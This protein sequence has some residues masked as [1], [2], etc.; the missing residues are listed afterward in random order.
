MSAFDETPGGPGMVGGDDIFDSSSGDDN[1][2][3]FNGNVNNVRNKP[4][5]TPG[6]PGDRYDMKVQY[7]DAPGRFHR[8]E[9]T[10]NKYGEVM[11]D[12]EF[13]EMENDPNQ[14]SFPKWLSSY[15]LEHFYDT[16]L[17]LGFDNVKMFSKC[18]DSNIAEIAKQLKANK[19]CKEGVLAIQLKLK[20]A[21]QD[22]MQDEY[23]KSLLMTMEEKQAIED[24]DKK[25]E[26]T[27]KTTMEF[28]ELFENMETERM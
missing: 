21:V 4:M 18:T 3:L 24:I 15:G 26:I 17:Q 8:Q 6:G 14:M 11:P 1:E 12:D 20:T 16:F 9:S 19:N 7:N 10:T 13:N 23:K 27:Q 2:D 25:I 22:L 28:T 5:I